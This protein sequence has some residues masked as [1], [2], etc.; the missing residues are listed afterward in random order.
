M[1]TIILGV[2]LMIL[3]IIYKRATRHY[4]YLESLGIPV[5]KPYLCFGSTPLNYHQLNFHS[6][7][8]EWYHKLKKPKAWGWYEGSLPTIAVMDPGMIKA[9]IAKEFDSFRSH[10][11]P[12][13]TIFEDKYLNLFDMQGDDKWKTIRKLLSPTFTSGKLKRMISPIAEQGDK[14]ISHL[15]AR[16]EVAGG[17]SNR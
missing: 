15:Q 14:F 4:G 10:Q 12:S 8:L 7:D 6:L 13:Q 3:V 5:I 1:L 9:I 2:I 11:S 17:D 16:V